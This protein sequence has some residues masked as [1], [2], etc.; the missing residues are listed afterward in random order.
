MTTSRRTAQQVSIRILLCL[1]GVVLVATN[2]AALRPVE[3]ISSTHQEQSKPH[4]SN[5]TEGRSVLDR[6]D[7]L[8]LEEKKNVL[9]SVL[10]QQNETL[11]AEQEYT[12][13]TSEIDAEAPTT[14]END[15]AQTND[16]AEH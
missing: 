13:A 14:A 15:N 7:S 12:R 2:Y 10:V 8:F 11:T 4:G 3:E 1:F 5:Q 9:R 16:L 6:L